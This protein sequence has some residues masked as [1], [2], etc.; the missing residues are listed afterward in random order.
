MPQTAC[1]KEIAARLGEAA[2]LSPSNSGTPSQVVHYPKLHHQLHLYQPHH[3]LFIMHSPLSAFLLVALAAL[4]SLAAVP[5]VRGQDPTT[6]LTAYD[7]KT[8]TSSLLLSCLLHCL[9][10]LLVT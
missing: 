10:S 2:L 1:G 7:P 9:T 6:Y 3:Q 5:T 8:V 4:L